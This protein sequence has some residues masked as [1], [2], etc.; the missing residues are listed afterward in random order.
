MVGFQCDCGKLSGVHEAHP[1]SDA[2]REMNDAKKRI[3]GD[4]S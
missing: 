3:L 1:S 4:E 2:V